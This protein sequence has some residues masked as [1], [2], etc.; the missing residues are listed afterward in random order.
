M[1]RFK[2]VSAL[3]V[4]LGLLTAPLAFA[5]GGSTAGTSTASGTAT[6]TAKAPAKAPAKAMT[7]KK[8][9]APKV[10]LNS[11][12]RD[13]LVKLPGIGEAIADKIIA[14]RPFKSKDELVRKNIVT[15]AEFAKMSSQIVAKRM[16][17]AK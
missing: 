2:S 16:P 5:Q 3:V 13:E 14:A 4:V 1:S 11:A 12:S 9:A 10:D 6:T 8:A 15:K 17:T 7:G